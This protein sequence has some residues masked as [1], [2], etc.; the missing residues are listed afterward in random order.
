MKN[1]NIRNPPP[2]QQKALLYPKNRKI[3]LAK[4]YS[5]SQDFNGKAL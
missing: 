1:I 5:T 4:D 2:A 3:L